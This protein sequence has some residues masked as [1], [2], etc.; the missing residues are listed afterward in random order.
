MEKQEII[1]FF[2]ACITFSITTSVFCMD[3]ESF[4]PRI[5][6]RKYNLNL[7]EIYDSNENILHIL[8]KEND[9]TEFTRYISINLQESIQKLVNKT[10][11]DGDSPYHYAIFRGCS[12]F[13]DFFR[14][15]FDQRPSNNKYN[16][17]RCNYR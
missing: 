9:Y 13:I 15:N 10:N 7:Q 4:G 8:V 2:I 12:L 16:Y 14:K 11:N 3:E 1:I 5:D 17:K 6:F